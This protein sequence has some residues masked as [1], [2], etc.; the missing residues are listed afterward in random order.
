MIVDVLIPAIVILLMVVVG[1]GLRA[2]QFSSV[3]R[4]P[5]VLAGGSL[6]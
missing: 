5:V 1:T 2:G 6:A 4:S 3:L